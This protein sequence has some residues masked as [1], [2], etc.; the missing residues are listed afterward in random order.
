[1]HCITDSVQ[2]LSCAWLFATPGTAACQASLSITNFQSLLKHVH[3]V[4]DAIQPS[5]PLSSPSPPGAASCRETAPASRTRGLLPAPQPSLLPHGSHCTPVTALLSHA[6]NQPTGCWKVTLPQ[7]LLPWAPVLSE[8][9]F[10]FLL[11]DSEHFSWKGILWLVRVHC[12]RCSWNMFASH[13]FTT[14]FL[15]LIRSLGRNN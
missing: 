10:N 12:L 5:H 9:W 13:T 15:H 3:R 6:E 1:M 4:G 11:W 8:M 2:L 14:I 7:S